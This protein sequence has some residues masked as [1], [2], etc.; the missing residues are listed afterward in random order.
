MRLALN[1]QT[2]A[3]EEALRRHAP[4]LELVRLSATGV[5]LGDVDAAL[6]PLVGTH[7]RVRLSPH[8]SWSAPGMV[9]RMPGVFLRNLEVFAHARPPEGVAD[10]A[11]G[12]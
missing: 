11:A 8:L 12:C 1:F 9:E 7:P 2:P 10:V 3:I 4:V 6:T 5:P